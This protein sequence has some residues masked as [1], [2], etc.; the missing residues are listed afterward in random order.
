MTHGL[1]DLSGRVAIVTGSTRGIGKAIAQALVQHGA[2]VAVSSRKSDA[3]DAVAS[4]INLGFP[5]AAIAVPC[6]ISSKDQ[7]QNLVDTTRD[8]FGRIDILVCNAAVNPYA[9]P[10]ADCPDEVFE[11]IMNSN[12]RS[13]HWLVN[14]VLPEMKHRRDGSVIVISSVGGL[15]G[16]EVLGTYAISKAADMQLVRNIAVEYG[17]HNVRAN[18]LAPGMIRTDFARYLWENPDTLQTAT[19]RAPLGRIGEPDDIAG[20]AVL[21][22]SPAG[23]FI[24]GQCIAIDGGVSVGS[25]V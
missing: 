13:T 12:V 7:L 14:M 8:S 22:A 10:M 17:P 16:S 23:A 21:L 4:G 6:N 1:F 11:K 24:T 20:A 2:R 19:A 3:C 18:T 25:L 15:F 9:G 5:G